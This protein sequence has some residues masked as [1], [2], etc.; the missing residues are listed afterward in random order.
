MKVLGRVVGILLLLV[1]VAV[2]VGFVYLRSSLPR[3]KGEVQVSGPGGPIEI[4]RDADAVPHIYAQ[5]RADAVFGLGFVH[6][7]DRLWQMEFQRRV[8]SGRLSEVIGPATLGTDRFIRTLGIRQAAA[9]ALEAMSPEARALLDAY[10]A[11][12]NA[13]LAQRRGAL[14]A[15]FLL[16]G[17]EPEPFD[18]VDVASWAKMMAWDLG[19]NW[20]DELLRAQLVARLAPEDAGRMI[21]ELWPSMDDAG[22]VVVPDGAAQYL[23]E[24]DVEGLLALAGPPKPDGYGSNNWV[25]AGDVTAT[26]KPI[27][28][29]DPHLGLQAPSLWYFAHLVA[30]DLNVIGAS[31]P[32]TPAVLLGRTDHHAWGFTN[33]G[34]DVQDLFLERVDPEDGGRYLTPNGSEAFAVRQETIKVKGQADEVIEVRSTR[35]GPVISDVDARSR[36]AAAG[37]LGGQ[38]TVVAFAWTALEP[39]DRTL[40]AVLGMNV[41]TSWDEFEDALRLFVAPMQNIVYADVDGVIAYYAPARIPVRAGGIGAL[42]VPGWTGEGDWVGYVPFEELP[43]SVQPESGRIV[44][45]NQRVVPDD[46]AHYLTRDWADPYRAERIGE[47]L[48]AQARATVDASVMAQLDQVS[49]M[50]REF[51]PLAQNAAAT[52]DGARRL[53]ALLVGFDGNMLAESRAPLA[54]AAWYRQFAFS[55]YRDDLGDVASGFFGLR[56]ALTRAILAG[57][58][59]WCDDTTTPGVETCE[60]QASLALDAAWRELVGAFG[61]DTSKWSWGEAHEA[62]YEHAV[63]GATPLAR[64]ANLRIG[65]GGDGFSVDAAGYG[66]EFGSFTQTHGPGYRGVYDLAGGGGWFIHGTGQ[67]GNLVSGHYRDYLA[68]WQSGAMIPMRMSRA[69]AEAGAMGTLR[70]VPRP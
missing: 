57:N 51:V 33:N 55:L 6:A 23:K 16:L 47:L 59:D 52:T 67:S 37:P 30:P 43:H 65:N 29:N 10:V 3:V 62:L 8:G 49:L 21:A 35:H 2:G 31:L 46:Y 28:A 1:I 70:L 66:L 26:G 53:Q 61:D 63:L 15:E 38:G 44:T 54:F 41:A 22:T 5:S 40:E 12:V 32:G 60:Q 56:P 48:D 24:I 36:E 20:G 17:F 45:A 58:P 69:E 9:S 64:V 18:A 14:P 50:A 4:V 27:L 19:D 11:G 13:Y 7:Q 39:G 25:L 68:R 42:P 34:A